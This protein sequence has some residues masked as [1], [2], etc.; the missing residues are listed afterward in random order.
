M[1]SR[2][3]LETG[4]FRQIQSWRRIGDDHGAAIEEETHTGKLSNARAAVRSRHSLPA[5]FGHDSR[6][7]IHSIGY[8]PRTY[9]RTPEKSRPQ[10]V[11]KPT[12]PE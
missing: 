8:A 1:D 10:I 11:P 6:H 7:P 9:G 4:D 5:D 2:I 12:I 3:P